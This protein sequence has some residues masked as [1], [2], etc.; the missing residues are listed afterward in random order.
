M[1]KQEF[2]EAYNYAPY[3]FRKVAELL[4]AITDDVD[5]ALVAKVFLDSRDDLERVLVDIGFEFG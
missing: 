1:T 5:T 2:L 4:S 3:E